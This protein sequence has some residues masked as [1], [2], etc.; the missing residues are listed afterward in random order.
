MIGA[1]TSHLH[2]PL[3]LVFAGRTRVLQRSYLS[4]LF[5]L[6]SPVDSMCAAFSPHSVCSGCSLRQVSLHC[7]PPNAVPHVPHGL[8]NL[9]ALRVSYAA[10]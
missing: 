9:S 6:I 3:P 10:G 2:T 5:P 7:P 1:I 8:P 4:L